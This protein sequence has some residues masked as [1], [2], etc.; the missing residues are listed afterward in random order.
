MVPLENNTFGTAQQRLADYMSRVGDIQQRANEAQEQIRTMRAE[1]SSAD[2]GVTVVLAPGG[3]LERLALT[4]QAMRL[5]HDG[6]AA[7]ITET[8]ARAHADAS[9]RMQATMQPLFGD[10]TAM[11]FLREQIQPPEAD[12]A[13]AAP[14][15]P[16]A[17]SWEDDDYDEPHGS[18]LR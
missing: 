8:V 18:M 15:R 3:R 10:S 1:V 7:L 14:G 12:D 2:G 16:A 17:G 5:G 11:D 6:L 4:P 9:A 13:P